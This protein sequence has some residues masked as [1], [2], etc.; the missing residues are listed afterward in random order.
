MEKDGRVTLSNFKTPKKTVFAKSS[1]FME[2]L[3]S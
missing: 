3:G 2:E 1:R